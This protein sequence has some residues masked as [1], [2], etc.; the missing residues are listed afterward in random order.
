MTPNALEVRLPSDTLW[1]V[2]AL[3]TGPHYVS[4]TASLTSLPL[5]V[6]LFL[7][8]LLPP[9][10]GQ[11]ERNR[12]K[13]FNQSKGKHDLWFH[14]KRKKRKKL[15]ACAERNT[16]FVFQEI[17]GV[18]AAWTRRSSPPAEVTHPTVTSFIWTGLKYINL[19]DSSEL[20]RF[21]LGPSYKTPKASRTQ[22]RIRF[23]SDIK[24]GHCCELIMFNDVLLCLRH[25]LGFILKPWFLHFAQ[26]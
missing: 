18:S 11:T 22:T 16:V 7:W 12:F 2:S 10:Q 26:L 13:E 23:Y 4:S 6:W 14:R 17:E 21:S 25:N 9:Y 15:S 8:Q 19:L 24:M 3:S 20:N 5:L 1:S